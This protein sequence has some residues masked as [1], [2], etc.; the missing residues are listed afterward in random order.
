MLEGECWRQD[1]VPVGR[2]A[3]KGGTE[4]SS[5]PTTRPN[6]GSRNPGLLPVFREHVF[7][8]VRQKKWKKKREKEKNGNAVFEGENCFG[9]AAVPKINKWCA[10]C[11]A[12]DWKFDIARLTV[13]DLSSFFF[14]FW[15]SFQRGTLSLY[16]VNEIRYTVYRLL[17]ILR[18]SFFRGRNYVVESFVVVLVR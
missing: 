8:L 9:R 11:V 4:R 16:V 12:N 5:G 1:T 15:L 7:F 17:E 10:R 14:T 13:L 3:P 6:R 2:R 18:F